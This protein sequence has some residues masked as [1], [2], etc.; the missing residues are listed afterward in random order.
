MTNVVSKTKLSLLKPQQPHAKIL[1]D[2]LY[3]DGFAHD[4]SSTGTGKTYIGSHIAKE[5]G[6]PVVVLC[7]KGVI[8]KWNSTLA[9]FGVTPLDVL[10]YE[11]MT[12]GSSKWLKYNEKV[13]MQ[14]NIWESKGMKFKFPL[15]TLVILDEVHK[16]KGLT[17]QASDIPIGLKDAG[18]KILTMSA[19]AATQVTEMKALGY[20]LELHKGEDFTDWCKDHGATPGYGGFLTVDRD[21]DAAIAGMAKVHH[22]IFHIKKNA[23]RLTDRDFEG[24]FPENRVISECYDMGVNTPKINAAYAQMEYEIAQLKERVAN[25]SMHVFAVMME[26][27]RRVELLK[28]PALADWINDMYDEDISPVVFLNFTDSILGLERI[29]QGKK[30]FDGKI[31]KVYGEMT[32]NQREAERLEFQAD[33]RRVYL[34][35]GDCGGTGIDMHDL[36][37]RYPRHTRI[38]PNWKAVNVCQCLGRTPRQGGKTRVLQGFFFADKTIETQIRDRVSFRLDNLSMLNDG[39]LKF[40]FEL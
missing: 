12:A 2:S 39:D 40:S 1:I 16:C 31:A 13:Y 29:L 25:Y 14:K 17:S 20:V 4:P 33:K 19:T 35:N 3:R 8:K 27:R 38:L 22:H 10:T 26:Q 34:A 7:P 37:G 23:S 11:K 30:K 32:P 5:L 15:N 9:D 24:I 28:V 36:H 21:S 18:Y 6:C